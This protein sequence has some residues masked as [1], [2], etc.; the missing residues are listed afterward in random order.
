MHI[1]THVLI[2][3]TLYKEITSQMEI[4]LDYLHFVYGNIKP[5]INP[6]DMDYPHYLEDSLED[7][8]SYCEHITQTPMSIKAMSVALGAVSHFICDY[9]CLYHTEAYKRKSIVGHTLYEHFLELHFIKKCIRRELIINDEPLCESIEDTISKNCAA[10]ADEK[11]SLDKD[12]HYAVNT[13]LCV[14]K[15]VIELSDIQKRQVSDMEI[16]YDFLEVGGSSL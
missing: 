3:N 15:R 5:D 6:G 16:A 8:I 13:T 2:A 10:Y 9:Y 7:V 4:Q 14:L 1:T 11:H 12:I